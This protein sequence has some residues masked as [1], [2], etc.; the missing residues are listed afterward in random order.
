MSAKRGDKK[1]SS[2]VSTVHTAQLLHWMIKSSN[3]KSVIVIVFMII[4]LSDCKKK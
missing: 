3:S 1:I 4:N 2:V